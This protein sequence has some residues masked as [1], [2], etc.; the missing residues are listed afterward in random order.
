MPLQLQGK[1]KNVEKINADDVESL[2]H[3]LEKIPVQGLTQ[4]DTSSE[5]LT[6]GPTVRS[7][8]LYNIAHI[9]ELELRGSI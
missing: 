3:F 6:S 1:W 9:N 4:F 8:K 7:H 5:P 2:I